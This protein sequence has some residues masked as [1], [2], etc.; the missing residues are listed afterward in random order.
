[1]KLKKS[2]LREII[3]EEIQK[4]NEAGGKKLPGY[5]RFAQSSRGKDPARLLF[6]SMDDGTYNKV[7]KLENFNDIYLPKNVKK[8]VA[9]QIIKDLKIKGLKFFDMQKDSSD[10][11][12][13]EPNIEGLEPREYDKKFQKLIGNKKYK[14]NFIIP[15]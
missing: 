1:M 14:V 7:K 12:I 8:Q 3:R 10:F 9:K 6:F 5:I 2:R 15:E 4:L 13:K 11:W